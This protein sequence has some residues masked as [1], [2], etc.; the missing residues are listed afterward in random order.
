LSATLPAQPAK[1]KASKAGLLVGLFI[2]GIVVGLAM[3]SQRRPDVLP[4]S[5]VTGVIVLIAIVLRVIRDRQQERLFAEVARHPPDPAI[6]PELPL[7][8]GVEPNR[9]L[10][11]A[12]REIG[13]LALFLGVP[14]GLGI[15]GMSLKQHDGGSAASVLGLAIVAGL[16]GVTAI[17]RKIEALTLEADVLRVG[18]LAIPLAGASCEIAD[19]DDWSAIF[20]TGFAGHAI[21]LRNGAASVVL[22]PAA[23]LIAKPATGGDLAARRL[24]GALGSRCATGNARYWL[25]RLAADAPKAPVAPPPP[26]VKPKRSAWAIAMTWLVGLITVYFL[27]CVVIGFVAGIARAIHHS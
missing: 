16:F 23:Y 4:E 11:R 27:V 21:E 10:V 15:A 12:S 7:P 17:R 14:A 2:S 19:K 5:A 26:M 24:F 13:V 9:H 1:K 6:S 22:Y 8:F 3:V 25:Q 20:G 18:D